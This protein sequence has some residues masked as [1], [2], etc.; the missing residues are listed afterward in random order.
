MPHTILY[1][2]QLAIPDVPDVREH[3]K[4]SLIDLKLTMLP[5]LLHTW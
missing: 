5:G 2:M 4:V 1:H 3:D